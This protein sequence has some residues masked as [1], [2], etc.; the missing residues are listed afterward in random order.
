VAISALLIPLLIIH[1]SLTLLHLK[2]MMFQSQRCV[3]MWQQ[4][5]YTVKSLNLV[6][7]TVGAQ[8]HKMD[9]S[10]PWH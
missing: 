1:Q 10:V 4:R 6:V 3:R 8:Q 9:D 5:N 2:K 7:S